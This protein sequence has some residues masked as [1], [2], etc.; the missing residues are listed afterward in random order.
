MFV[1]I[2]P[3]RIYTDPES[4]FNEWDQMGLKRYAQALGAVWLDGPVHAT[5]CFTRIEQRRLFRRAVDVVLDVAMA[6]SVPAFK[7]LGVATYQPTPAP[8]RK[9]PSARRIDAITSIIAQARTG[10]PRGHLDPQD[11]QLYNNRYGE[12]AY[13]VAR[14]IK[15]RS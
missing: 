13:N 7:R 12:V 1:H 8:E 6:R 11:P 5:V 10:S 2:E 3:V 15:E 14:H 4:H 9:A